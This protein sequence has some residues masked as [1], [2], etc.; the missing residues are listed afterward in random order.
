MKNDNPFQAIQLFTKMKKKG[1]L[2]I[3]NQQETNKEIIAC[4]RMIYLSMINALADYGDLSTSEWFVKQI[5][6]SFLTDVQVHG[7]LIHMW[8]S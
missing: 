2:L 5:P 6:R 3:D 7:A 1:L 8:V 4:N